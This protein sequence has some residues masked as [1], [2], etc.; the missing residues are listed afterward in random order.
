MIKRTICILLAL[1][2]LCLPAAA[3][4]DGRELLFEITGKLIDVLGQM[5]Q[6][7]PYFW[8]YER[9]ENA[10]YE[11]T[12]QCAQILRDLGIDE[13]TK[14]K[15]EKESCAA[16][17]AMQEEMA[18]MGMDYAIS[19]EMLMLWLL[20][21]AGSIEQEDAQRRHVYAFDTEV[22]DVD[23]MYADFLKGIES[24]GNG[25]LRFENITEDLGGVDWETGEG[26]RT[27]TFDFAGKTMTY[28]AA[29]QQ[30]WF[31]MGMLVF[32]HDAIGVSESGRQ[33]YFVFDGMQGV[34]LFYQTPQWA[35]E[36]TKATG[37]PLFTSL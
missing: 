8:V 19:R 24:I 27:V 22:L 5:N 34:I 12:A 21:Y 18:Q 6:P 2:A 30:D 16:M 7:D 13:V 9:S 10:G 26:T 14:E 25:E 17:R 32:L 11:D 15:V 4:Q 3:E 1:C 37:C 35:R 29:A 31:D 28:E 36:F 20:S 23:S 33:L